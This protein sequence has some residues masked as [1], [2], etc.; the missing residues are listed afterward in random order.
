MTLSLMFPRLVQF[1]VCLR[2]EGWMKLYVWVF[3][4]ARCEE[5]VLFCT[6]CL[7]SRRYCIPCG[8]EARSASMLKA[9]HQYQQSAKGRENHR[10]RQERWR[11]SRGGSV[12]GEAAEVTESA[13][14][15]W[16][17]S[18]V[19]HR[20]GENVA[21]RYAKVT[22]TP[23]AAAYVTAPLGVDRVIDAQGPNEGA[24]SSPEQDLVDAVREGEVA[25]VWAKET[26]AAV[27][28]S[29]RGLG[30]AGGRI[31]GRCSCCGRG[32]ELVAYDGRPRIIRGSA[33]ESGPE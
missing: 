17:W 15:G 28:A 23:T 3:E 20:S 8:R 32:G 22:G 9:G 16:A 30:C 4:C 27:L 12:A 31:T 29:L 2:G 14:A 21:S 19:T 11:C 18:S 25:A 10:Q 7:G 6:R 33:R 13:S 5:L 24:A 1:F 26:A